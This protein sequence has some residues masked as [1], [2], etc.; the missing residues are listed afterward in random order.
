MGNKLMPT[1]RLHFL[2]F[3]FG[4]TVPTKDWAHCAEIVF[5]QVSDQ[6]VGEVN[7][8][9]SST[10]LPQCNALLHESFSYESLSAFPANLSIAPY[11][12]H[13]VVPRVFVPPKCSGKTSSTFPIEP[14][15]SFLSQRLVRTKVVVATQ[16]DCGAMLLPTTNG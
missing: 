12:A 13:V 14:D 6:E 3:G 15:R 7:G 8:I 5:V 2:F 10:Q 16:P 4:L 11:L 9:N 1:H